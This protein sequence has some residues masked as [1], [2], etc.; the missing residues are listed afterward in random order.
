MLYLRCTSIYKEKKNIIYKN[1]LII[2]NTFANIRVNET[3]IVCL[4]STQNNDESLLT[5][6]LKQY[7][8]SPYVILMQW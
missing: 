2:N 8:Y 7:S 1:E 4:K 6:E 3:G 5:F